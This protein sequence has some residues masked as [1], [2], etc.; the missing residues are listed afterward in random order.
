MLLEH[1]RFLCREAPS[2]YEGLCECVRL[3]LNMCQ[4]V[5]F[6][7]RHSVLNVVFI[8]LIFPFFSLDNVMF[9]FSFSLKCL[10]WNYSKARLKESSKIC[11]I[12]IQIICEKY[13]Y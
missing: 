12:P 4:R 1:T 11:R 10:P 2:G 3:L 8:K 13:L 6:F 5:L 7:L 9:F